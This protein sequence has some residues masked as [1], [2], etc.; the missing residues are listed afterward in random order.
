MIL[1]FLQLVY[2]VQLQ[3]GTCNR[4]EDCFVYT[5][6]F[7]NSKEYTS[8]RKE[9][10]GFV[11]LN[12][13][14]SY[15]VSTGN[16]CRTNRDCASYAYVQSVVQRNSTESLAFD[17]QSWM[18]NACAPQHCN[19]ESSCETVS[20]PFQATASEKCCAGLPTLNTCESFKVGIC[21]EGTT[22]IPDANPE[23]S[24][25]TCAATSKT[26]TQ[27]IG[28]L[29]TFIGAATSNVGLN[30]QKYAHRK[31]HE[32][33]VIKRERSRMGFLYGLSNIRVSLANLYKNVSQRSLSRSSTL[34]ADLPEA[35]LDAAR[36][37][38]RRM[39]RVKI[40][41]PDEDR[42]EFQKKLNMKG[43]FKNPVFI[44]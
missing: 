16:I 10:A 18:E 1:L 19:L 4:M 35:S 3:I 36:N 9:Q 34:K 15:A 6:R 43:L 11:C 20:N 24:I 21:E 28:I 37:Q 31:R 41:A 29:L 5:E 14:C 8:E 26:S 7:V 40:S 23:S 27:W 30:V 13:T 12:Q 38:A 33:R 32:K 44:F 39:S 2:A 17:Y 42:A 22:C 25:R